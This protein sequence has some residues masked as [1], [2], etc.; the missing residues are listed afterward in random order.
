MPARSGSARRPRTSSYPSRPGIMTSATTRSGAHAHRRHGLEPVGHELDVVV[1]AE[2]VA[3]EPA[4]VRVVLGDEDPR[5]TGPGA[6]L[7]GRRDVRRGGDPLVD[8]AQHV[9]DSLGGDRRDAERP[10]P[11]RPVEGQPH[12]EGAAA[13]Q[14]AR[15]GDRAAHEVGQLAHQGQADPAPSRERAPGRTGSRSKRSNARSTSS[16]AIPTPVSRT[17][18]STRS[19]R[20]RSGSTPSPQGCTSARCSTGS[21]P[22]ARTSPGPRRPVRAGPRSGRRR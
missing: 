17:A 18:S 14:P 7:H 5:Q 3:E 8:L 11:G 16:A 4:Q 1:L 21:A 6:V 12:R 20:D 15:H 22:P 9:V 13:A 19:S 10:G 2:D